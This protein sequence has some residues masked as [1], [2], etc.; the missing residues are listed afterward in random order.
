MIKNEKKK[1]NYSKRRIGILYLRN[2]PLFSKGRFALI[3]LSFWLYTLAWLGG[4]VY[5]SLWNATWYKKAVPL[6]LLIIGT[7]AIEDL[8]MGYKRYRRIWEEHNRVPNE[9]SNS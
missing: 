1:V 4:L 9:D 2:A 6:I 8:L 5:I 7:P 3:M